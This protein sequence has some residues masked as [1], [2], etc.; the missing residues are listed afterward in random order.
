MI[1]VVILVAYV[2]PLKFEFNSLMVCELLILMGMPTH[3]LITAEFEDSMLLTIHL[4]LQNV[5]VRINRY[6]LFVVKIS[7]NEL[8]ICVHLFKASP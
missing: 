2:S 1:Q 4:L 7:K 6:L 8:F 5:F 3:Q